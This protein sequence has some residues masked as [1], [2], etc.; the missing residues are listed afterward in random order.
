VSAPPEQRLPSTWDAAL[1]SLLQP[2]E[3]ITAFVEGDLN[4]RLQF[5]KSLVVITNQRL[6]VVHA[7][8]N[9]GAAQE[10]EHW[11]L[12]QL[13]TVRSKEQH[14]LGVIEFLGSEE[15]LTTLRYTA[16]KSN[17]VARFIYGCNHLLAEQRG[18]KLDIIATVCP[19]CGTVLSSGE[20]E[21]PA[22]SITE[23]PQTRSLFRLWRFAKPYTHLLLLGLVLTLSGTAATLV[24]PYL[25]GQLIDRV[26]VPHFENDP[27]AI[28][29]AAVS[30]Y[31]YGML[32]AAVLAWLL[33][34]ARSYVIANGTEYIVSE[35]RQT[36]F[37]HLQ[38]LSLEFFGG[39]RTG[40]LITRVSSDSDKICQFLSVQLVEFSNDIVMIAMVTGILVY[41][42]PWLAFVTLLPF[43]AIA[44]L[45]Q[46]VRARLRHYFAYGNRAWSSMV[47]VLADTIPG[48]RVVK[49]FAQEQREV[50][51]FREADEC[52]LNANIRVNR[53]WAFF[54]P[55]IVLLTEIGLLVIWAFGAWQIR[56]Q[57]VSVGNLIVF[58]AYLSRFYIRL[59]SMS[60]MVASAQRTVAASHRIFEILDRVPSV[61]EP[62][63]PLHPG[64]VQGRVELKGVR[65]SYGK[66]EVIK[67]I[68]LV[69]EPGEMIGLVGPSGAGKSTLVNLVCRFFDVASG[70]I[71]V[72]GVDIRSFAT[73][74]Y[75]SNIGIV[76]QDPFLFYGTIGENIAYGRPQA[77]R[78]EIVAAAKA[79]KAHEFILRLQDGYDSLVGERGQSL[80][81]GERQR[82]SIARALLTDPRLLI[83][84][85]ATSSVDT[86]T[87]HEIQEALDVLTR[88]R[89]TIAI[90]H[91]LSTLRNA[92]RIVVMESGQITEIGTHE[93]LL[94]RAGTYARL[95]QSQNDLAHGT[96]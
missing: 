75:R 73:Q 28:T 70:A 12:S 78:R 77:T 43:P 32:A 72:D 31:L 35:I 83:L 93:E 11:P 46:I 57:A 22:C 59:E 21:C 96:H 52:V 14:G 20:S 19:S 30:P 95:C 13:A 39:K 56:G 26:L 24:G 17:A 41:L 88:G 33:G 49:A 71:F 79:A 92:N 36:T 15:R 76:L 82:I 54:T 90:A 40:D 42:D 48:I 53:I 8:A 81:G 9:G 10:S 87:E 86:E 27:E 51:R 34:W 2:N 6:I 5:G 47:S 85:E 64:R 65:F 62:V 91:R 18:E 58:V 25:S 23:T 44:W 69:I 67:G 84:D 89:T 3:T 7:T 60:R 1:R 38:K 29:I 50:E 80:S 55:I 63:K 16:A 94:E 66:R 68:D 4:V 45:I 61:A 37:N 74:E